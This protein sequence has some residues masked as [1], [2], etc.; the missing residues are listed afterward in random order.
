MPH[1]HIFKTLLAVFLLLAFNMNRHFT[2][3]SMAQETT[4]PEAAPQKRK[5]AETVLFLI[6]RSDEKNT[7]AGFVIEPIALKF[8]SQFVVPPDKIL[9][10]AD[11]WLEEEFVER[12][13]GT[14]GEH[15]THRLLFGGGEIGTVTTTG[16]RLLRAGHDCI[17]LGT[18]VRVNTKIKFAAHE[19]AL[20]TNSPTLGQGKSLRR[21]ATNAERN[22][23]LR[24]AREYL[25]GRG[26]APNRLREIAPFSIA[27]VD[28]DGDGKWE[29][30][31]SFNVAEDASNE[32]SW[33]HY[34]FF[35]LEPRGAGYQR[36]MLDASRTT[37]DL[38]GSAYRFVDILDLNADGVADIFAEADTTEGL[39]QIVYQKTKNKWRVI[40]DRAINCISVE[41]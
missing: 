7:G 21:A 39:K 31:A 40:Y 1:T 36:Y 18:D 5:I 13:Y 37:P 33:H 25:K 10:P 8:G 14:K 2:P 27:A 20:A 12:Y 34:L 41:N 24:S 26:V 6:K 3:D 15:R 23:V 35:V 9:D 38:Y 4:S 19:M 16:K 30:I 28:L 29:L 17:A 22:A 11:K 32:L